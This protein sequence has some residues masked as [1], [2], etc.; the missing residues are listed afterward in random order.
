MWQS[1]LNC[2]RRE[3]KLDVVSGPRRPSPLFD[4]QGLRLFSL[5][6]RAAEP[7]ITPPNNFHVVPSNL[8]SC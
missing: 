7:E 4:R 6:D 2:W 5:C 3:R 1:L 8:S